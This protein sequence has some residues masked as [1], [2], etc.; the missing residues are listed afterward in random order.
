MQK[1]NKRE[2]LLYAI[3]RKLALFLVCGFILF[4]LLLFCP[5][6]I[7]IILITLLVITLTFILPKSL[8]KNVFF[9][10]GQ[11]FAKDRIGLAFAILII[12]A[13]FVR[14]EVFALI[15]V[16]PL[17]LKDLNNITSNIIKIVNKQEQNI[18]LLEGGEPLKI[19]EKFDN[20]TTL[21]DSYSYQT[22]NN[23]KYELYKLVMRDRLPYLFK[24]SSSEK[25]TI[26]RILKRYK[27]LGNRIKDLND[28]ENKLKVNLTSISYIEPIDLTTHYDNLNYY[29]NRIINKLE[30]FEQINLNDCFIDETFIPVTEDC[31]KE[32]DKNDD[33]LDN[34]L[35]AL[36]KEENRIKKR[37]KHLEKIE[38]I[39]ISLQE[40]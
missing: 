12:I 29:I 10:N 27:D 39:R 19:Q 3:L 4:L 5:V 25:I 15:N 40:K 18:I 34:L 26:Q 36:T 37:E 23:E 9:R 35:L 20:L 28:K 13:L 32:Y 31:V 24:H 21:M 2:F 17:S 8:V 16:T 22:K 7:V 14:S 33:I 38:K 6:V 11:L 1:S 30:A